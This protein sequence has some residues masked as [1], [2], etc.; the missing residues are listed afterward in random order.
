MTDGVLGAVCLALAQRTCADARTHVVRPP[1]V[2]GDETQWEQRPASL[3][4]RP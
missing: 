1:E 3:S 2:G 4:G